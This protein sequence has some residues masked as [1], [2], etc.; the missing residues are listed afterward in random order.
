MGLTLPL[1][2]T[3]SGRQDNEAGQG[4][5]LSDLSNVYNMGL[6]PSGI[7]G[8]RTLYVKTVILQKRYIKP[9]QSFTLEYEWFFLQ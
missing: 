7:P 8:I 2:L 6:L 4:P 3:Y 1:S 9:Q 5:L